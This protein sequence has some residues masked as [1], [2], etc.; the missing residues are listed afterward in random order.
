MGLSNLRM[1]EISTLVTRLRTP[2]DCLFAVGAALLAAITIAIPT[3]VL[4]NPWFVRM[5]PV[6]ALDYFFLIAS[7]LLVGFLAAT[8]LGPKTGA[9]TSGPASGALLATLAIGCPICN[10]LVVLAIGVSGALTYFEP[11]QPLLGAV[12]LAVLAWGLIVRLRGLVSC[13]VLGP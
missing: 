6:R 9:S 12:G 4:D 10:K 8:Y 13:P 7:S 11:V 2:R 1:A 3:A 5:T